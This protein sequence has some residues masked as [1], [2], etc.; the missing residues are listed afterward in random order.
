MVEID[1]KALSRDWKLDDWKFKMILNQ[2]ELRSELQKEAS[3]PLTALRT[4]HLPDMGVTLLISHVHTPH[5]RQRVLSPETRLATGSL[6]HFMEGK[7]HKYEYFQ[8]T[9]NVM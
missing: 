1:A 4:L 5:V 3:D 8:F 9:V 7:T 6:N 2:E